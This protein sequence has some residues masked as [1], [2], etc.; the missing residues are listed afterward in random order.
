MAQFHL[1]V[2]NLAKGVMW[3]MWGL[4]CVS[5]DGL[6]PWHLGCDQ[7]LGCRGL[8]TAKYTALQEG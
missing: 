6:L 3:R 8:C 2:R 4:S 7:V 5:M 1:Q